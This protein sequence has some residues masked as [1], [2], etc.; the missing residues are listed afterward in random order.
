MENLDKVYRIALQAKA[1]GRLKPKYQGMTEEELFQHFVG[2]AN[3]T[4]AGEI[5]ADRYKTES[6]N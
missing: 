3:R 4:E 2:R 5:S 6:N 1:E